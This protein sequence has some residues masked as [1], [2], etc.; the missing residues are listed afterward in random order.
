MPLLLILAFSLSSASAHASDRIELWTRKPGEHGIVGLKVD[1][2]DVRSVT[3]SKLEGATAEKLDIQYGE[4]KRFKGVTLKTLIRQYKPKERGLD[5]ALL[6]FDNGMIIPVRLDDDTV[7][8]IDAF[9][10]TGIESQKGYSRDFPPITREK[11]ANMDQ[12]PITF[13]D[14]KVVV[15]SAWFPEGKHPDDYFSPWRHVDSLKG[16]E[17]ANRAAY[18]RQ[19]EASE[20]TSAGLGVFK[21]RCQFCHS[22]NEMGARFG[23]DF[24]SPMPVH[25]YKNAKQ[26]LI[27]VSTSKLAAID[28]GLMMPVQRTMTEEES[29]ALLKWIE[30]LKKKGDLNAYEPPK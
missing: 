21:S 7:D 2:L 19:F 10:A 26:L 20:A 15:S 12:R 30:A 1:K 18:E 27:H 11:T 13:A 5:L 29:A 28:Q 22:V 9:V 25:T 17:F 16:V 4:K 14:N 8:R 3:L 6:H 24:L 23:W